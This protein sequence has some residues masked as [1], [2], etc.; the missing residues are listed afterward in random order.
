MTK[1]AAVSL[2]WLS[3][4]AVS[5]FIRFIPGIGNLNFSA[6]DKKIGESI[7]GSNIISSARADTPTPTPPPDS[8]SS[9]GTCGTGGGGY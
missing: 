8:C 5:F 6:L 9:T 2:F 3:A 4:F 1:R 7:S